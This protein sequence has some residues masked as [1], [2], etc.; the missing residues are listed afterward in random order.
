MPNPEGA[1]QWGP[2]DYPPDDIL[3]K[4]LEKYVAYGLT[5]EQKLA[6][7]KKDHNLEI[8]IRKLTNLQKRLSVATV[9]KPGLEKEVLEEH[10]TEQVLKDA[11]KRQGPGTI[12][13][14]LK[15]KKILV[16]RR[17]VREIMKALVPEG[18]D[19]RY[20]GNKHSK[21]HRTPLTSLGPFNEIS[22][23]GHE[24]LDSKTLQMG[25]ISL[26]IYV[27][28]DKFSGYIL[29]LVVLPD[30]RKAVALG[31]V[32]LDLMSEIGGIPIQMTT[33]LGSEVGW[34]YA[35]QDTSRRLFA[36]QVDPDVFPTFVTIKSVHNTVSESLWRFLSDISGKNL[37]EV[38]LYG[39]EFHIFNPQSDMH[40]DLFYWVFVPLIQ[41]ELD[42][43]R[44]MWNQHKV[45]PQKEKEMPSGHTPAD[46][47]EYPEEYNGVDC[48]IKV[49]EDTQEEE[50]WLSWYG[51]DFAEL[52]EAAYEEIGSP[53]L[54]LETA[55]TVFE[56][57]APHL[58]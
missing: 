7:L 26:P 34:Q 2:K 55:W 16:P 48:L 4:S 36:P 30:A 41:T 38:V 11:S 44:T 47:F 51:T 15:D 42:E 13:S 37:R 56:E 32:F 31:H 58:V 19:I 21:P 52:A 29:K 5:R 14:R 33:D 49:P 23:D 39:K 6:R 35:F 57:M 1:N 17:V 18:F 53:E 10:V 3:K 46:A 43:F 12:K 24:K 45:R 27:Y 9:R 8:S 28:R 54:T 40:C 50:E 22:A 20:P 25:T